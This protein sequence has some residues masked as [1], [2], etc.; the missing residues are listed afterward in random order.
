MQPKEE[1]AQTQLS[2]KAEQE[3]AI[4]KLGNEQ[5]YELMTN[6]EVSWHAII[7]DLINTGQLDP[8]DINL[9]L[10]A[11]KYLERI[12]FLE[13]ANFFISSKV[14]LVASVLLRFKSDILLYEHIKSI[15]EI[16]FGKKEEEKKVIERIE[17]DENSL[18]LLYPKTPLPRYKKV[19]LQELMTAL[20][21]AMTT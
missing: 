10:L 11:N 17:I 15:D 14:L 18:P 13:E 16:L 6:E 1:T 19:T 3:I 2:E 20:D 4:N 7:N 5:I 12:K 21:K 9:A 8:W